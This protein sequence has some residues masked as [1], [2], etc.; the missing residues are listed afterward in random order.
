MSSTV[1]ITTALR[2]PRDLVNLKLQDP[3]AR[4]V[5][6]KA[7]IYFWAAQGIGSIVIAD[8]TDAVVLEPAEVAVLAATGVEVEQI[9]YA[10]DEARVRERG[11]GYA[12]GLL[13]AHALGNSRL[14][15]GQEHFFKC[16]G[17]VYCRNLAKLRALIDR[18]AMTGLFWGMHWLD[19]NVGRH[20]VDT[21]FFYTSQTFLRVL[22]A[23]GYAEANDNVG[24]IVEGTVVGAVDAHFRKGF[25]PRALLSGF[26][27]GTG[28]M[29]AEASLGELDAAFPCWYAKQ[30]EAAPSLA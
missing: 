1:L 4:S 24:K 21:R 30:G 11:K 18:N 8:A 13:L 6:T 29:Y 26:A 22:L 23:A 15:A 25:A 2:P 3:A 28:R 17:K 20:L 12:E 7:A 10:Q 19:G 16:T 27:G 14:L 9:R 5:A